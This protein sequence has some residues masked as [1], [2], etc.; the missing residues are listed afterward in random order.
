[1][2]VDGVN[3]IWVLEGGYRPPVELVY[4][5][6]KYSARGLV[7]NE[8]PYEVLMQ[9]VVKDI[10]VYC[11]ARIHHPL[12]PMSN[13]FV[14]DPKYFSGTI[15][16]D[17][18]NVVCLQDTY[19][20]TSCIHGHIELVNAGL[21]DCKVDADGMV[22]RSSLTNCIVTGKIDL[23]DVISCRSQLLNVTIKDASI[24][25][26]VLSRIT[27]SDVYIYDVHWWKDVP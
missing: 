26:C 12:N 3:H 16:S 24:M 20:N 10:P 15:R 27:I 8:S 9:A 5:V 19:I 13:W 23:K 11:E 7:A 2:I 21:K 18:G 14:G 25:D 6:D 1:M 4:Q 22:D 17:V